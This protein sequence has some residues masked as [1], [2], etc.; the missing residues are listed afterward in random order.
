MTPGS[1]HPFRPS[2]DRARCADCSLGADAPTH[3]VVV[4][5]A[6]SIERRLRPPGRR[7]RPPGTG[8]RSRAERIRLGLPICIT[9]GCSRSP[10]PGRNGK[11]LERCA[12]CA[13][14]RARKRLPAGPMAYFGF[15][16]PVA[17]LGRAEIAAA[18]GLMSLAEWVRRAMGEAL[19]RQ[20]PASSGS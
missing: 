1:V 2:A 13:R 14:G 19:E 6:A 9:P 11:H 7:G 3:D 17:L 18:E 4:M 10:R 5:L 15:K 12:P 20:T 8:N 16:V